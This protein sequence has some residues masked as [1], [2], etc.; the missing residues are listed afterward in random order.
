MKRLLLPLALVGLFAS[1]CLGDDQQPAK[2]SGPG[3]TTERP[4]GFAGD[5]RAQR[6]GLALIG[7]YEAEADFPTSVT[8]TRSP[9]PRS[10]DPEQLRESIRSQTQGKDVDELSDREIDGE[11]AVGVAAT[12]PGPKGELRSRTYAVVRG[13]SLYT[14]AATAAKGSSGDG[15]QALDKVVDAWRWR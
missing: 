15:E 7:P 2:V 12:Q 6:D 10:S 8:V 5:D 1:G 4:E 13:R 11:K 9:A 14:I 3:F